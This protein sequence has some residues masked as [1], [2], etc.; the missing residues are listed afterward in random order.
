MEES[1][2]PKISPSDW[3]KI[4][5][6]SKDQLIIATFNTL[7]KNYNFSKK[8]W[9]SKESQS[10]EY[11]LHLHENLLSSLNA[12]IICLQEAEVATFQEDFGF[13]N[14]LGYT[15][16][17]PVAKDEAGVIHGHTKPSIFFK[18]SRF[19]LKWHNPRSRIV[20]ANFE[21]LITGKS[22]YI[23]NC[24]LQAGNEQAQRCFQLRSAL[25]QVIIHAQKAQVKDDDLCCIICGDFNSATV[26]PVHQLILQGHLEDNGLFGKSGFKFTHNFKFE[27]SHGSLERPFTFKWGVK[28]DAAFDV[29]DYIY[30]T[31]KTMKI[32][33]V[34][35]PLDAKQKRM[36][37]N[38]TGLPNDW[39]P[40]DHL[41]VAAL[42]Q[43]C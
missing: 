4:P 36:I 41:P 38:K 26:E 6:Q 28:D 7:R 22:F 20:L 13:M 21:D 11:R 37:K 30:F 40:S 12:D 2:I 8:Y 5:A 10:W 19:N 9:I 34:R 16:I 42:L 15:A 25:Q 32:I 14:S 24:H 33:G 29:F 27:D 3:S 18:T 39:H 17:Q 35:D 23:I 1:Y 31:P 43:F